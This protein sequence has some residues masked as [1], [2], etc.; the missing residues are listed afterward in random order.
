MHQGHVKT[1]RTKP[2][3][4]HNSA[5]CVFSGLVIGW[6]SKLRAR[7]PM[8]VIL[9]LVIGKGQKQSLHSKFKDE[10]G[11]VFTDPQDISL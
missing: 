5:G 1:A 2:N 7:Y 11:S 6:W 4:Q 3:D 10:C 9:L 8:E